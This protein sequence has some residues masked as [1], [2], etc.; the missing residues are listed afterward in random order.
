MVGYLPPIGIQ[1]IMSPALR[2]VLKANLVLLTR[3]CLHL[4]IQPQHTCTAAL[5]QQR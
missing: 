1:K 5:L 3:A 2:C 4:K